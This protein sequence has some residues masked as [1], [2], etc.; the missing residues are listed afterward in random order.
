MRETNVKKTFVGP[1]AEYDQLHKTA[2]SSIDI[3]KTGNLVVSA[4]S[5]NGLLIWNA[6]NADIL[7]SVRLIFKRTKNLFSEN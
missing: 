4:D 2:V 5:S 6:Q 3:S 7:V 1:V